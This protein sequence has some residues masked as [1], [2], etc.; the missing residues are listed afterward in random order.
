MLAAF[1]IKRHVSDVCFQKICLSS[2][3]NSETSSMSMFNLQIFNLNLIFSPQQSNGGNAI[4]WMREERKQTCAIKII[5]PESDSRRITEREL[6]EINKRKL[7]KI[8]AN[9][10]KSSKHLKCC[11]FTS[12]IFK[13]N[14]TAKYLESLL[15]AHHHSWHFQLHLNP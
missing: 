9:N 11:C 2:C 5:K 14:S 3:V 1:A 13:I 7:Q 6:I 10:R 15:S 12:Y 4:R 8:I